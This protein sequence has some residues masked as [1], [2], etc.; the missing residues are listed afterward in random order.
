MIRWHANAKARRGYAKLGRHE[1]DL[2]LFTIVA[3]IEFWLIAAGLA[4][5]FVLPWVGGGLLGLALVVLVGAF[6]IE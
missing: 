6:L 5:V 1:D 2:D 3:L 4:L